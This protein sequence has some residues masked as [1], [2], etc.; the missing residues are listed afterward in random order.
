MTRSVRQ[1]EKQFT[2]VGNA[3]VAAIYSS[4]DGIS[5]E[6]GAD[7]S[8]KTKQT[9]IKSWQHKTE[10]HLHFYPSLEWHFTEIL[11][12]NRCVTCSSLGPKH[13][14]SFD[15][16]PNMWHKHT[17]PWTPSNRRE[18]FFTCRSESRLRQLEMSNDFQR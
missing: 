17:S 5:N 15:S 1:T 11:K 9:N 16:D 8:T 12:I 6:Q 2:R 13:S 10:T 7:T 18:E 14:R 3:P 4:N